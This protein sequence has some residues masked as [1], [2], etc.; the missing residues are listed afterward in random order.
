MQTESINR[1]GL[2]QNQANVKGQ[3][4]LERLFHAVDT[5]KSDLTMCGKGLPESTKPLFECGSNHF[6]VR[7]K[8][9]SVQKVEYRFDP[10]RKTLSRRV[11]RKKVERVLEGVTDF[12][13]TFFP[14]SK[15]VLYRVEISKKENIRGYIFLVNMVN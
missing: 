9:K 15:S 10:E 14:E 5:I 13:V 1:R 2:L 4:R 7:Y 8:R 3:Q 11:N 12:Y 6:S